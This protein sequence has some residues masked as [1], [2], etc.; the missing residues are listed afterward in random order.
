MQCHDDNLDGVW[1][2]SDFH[3]LAAFFS[4]PKATLTGMQD[5]ARPY[6]YTYLDEEES[7]TVE[8]NVPFAK[9]SLAEEGPHRKRL[10]RWITSDSNK[11]F[12][13]AMVNR[14]WAL[15]YGKPLVEPIDSI[16][17]EGPYPAGLEALADD[18]A[19]NGHDLK[20]L[21]KVVTAIKPFRL[22]SRSSRHEITSAHENAW[23]SFPVTRL[24]PEQVAGAIVQSS[25]LATVDANSHVIVRLMKFGRTDDF[26]KRYGDVGEDEFSSDGGT[27]PQRLV[28]LNG[29]LIKELTKD[30]IVMNAATRISRFSPDD[31]RAIE[32]AYLAV[33]TRY[34]TFDEK[35]HFLERLEETNNRVQFFEDLFWVLYNST[36]FSWNH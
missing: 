8:P 20:R 28:V 16:P 14:V 7:T 18:F 10:A 3:E 13:R 19:K 22:D 9:E 30:D 36:E 32:T 26:V 6:E 35:Q 27:I 4:G 25:K 15:A 24:R 17:L 31:S 23:A 2:Q 34:P 5:K 21:W 12:S 1:L 11:A 29:N 33:M